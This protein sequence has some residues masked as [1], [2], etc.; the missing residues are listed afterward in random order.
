MIESEQYS[1]Q[2]VQWLF[3]DKQ[4]I[5]EI[6][7]HLILYKGIRTNQSVGYC[8][9][10]IQQLIIVVTHKLTFSIFIVPTRYRYLLLYV[11]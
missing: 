3:N 7:N 6:L 1:L 5:N 10:F 2:T 9:N 8:Y 4:D 11:M